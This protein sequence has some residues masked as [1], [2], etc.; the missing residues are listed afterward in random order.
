M[1]RTGVRSKNLSE[2]DQD[3]FPPIAAKTTVLSL[4]FCL[5]WM[6]SVISKFMFKRVVLYACNWHIVWYRLSWSSQQ[7]YP[8][9]Q[10]PKDSPGTNITQVLPISAPNAYLCVSLVHKIH[11]LVYIVTK[12]VPGDS[13][14]TCFQTLLAPYCWVIVDFF[15][16][17]AKLQANS[18]L[19]TKSQKFWL[20]LWC[21]LVVVQTLHPTF[22]FR[23]HWTSLTSSILI[24]EVCTYLA[25]QSLLD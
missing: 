15:I 2:F 24:N 22:T 12:I 21:H 25:L 20:T 5:L 16:R 9:L 17:V 3:F 23:C 1:A 8:L 18:T 7:C 4:V 11:F 14:E 10:F 6:C 19:A 13:N